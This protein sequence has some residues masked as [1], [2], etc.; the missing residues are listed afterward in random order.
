M[1]ETA[2]QQSRYALGHSDRELKRLS[3][4]A[5]VFEPFTRQ[6][7]QQARITRGMRVLDVGCGSGDVALLASELVGPSGKVIGCRPGHISGAASN[8]ARTRAADWE[9]AI[10]RRRPDRNAI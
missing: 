3:R 2:A 4:Q 6:L 7:F 9:C 1:K 10:L 5:E 8:R